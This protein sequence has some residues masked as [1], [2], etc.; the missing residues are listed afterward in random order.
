MRSVL[1]FLG[2]Q[3]GWFACVLGAV[4]DQLLL[5]ML[6]GLAIIAWHLVR[7][8]RSLIELISLLMAGVIGTL[9]ESSLVGMGW[10][11]YYNGT[12]VEGMAP[13]WITMLWLLFATTFNLSLHW[14]RRRWLMAA[15]F[16]ALGAPGAFYAGARLGA[17]ELVAMPEALL[18]QALG[19]A[20]LVPV[21]L[22]I[23]LSFDGYAGTASN[24]ET[25]TEGGKP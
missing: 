21:L 2:Y 4:Y 22:R 19:Y 16:S 10:I 15:I 11:H 13:F 23:S 6:I 14:L 18:A 7:A 1:N 8:G 20:V 25:A 9:W 17:L 5:G 3:I 12:Y 24:I